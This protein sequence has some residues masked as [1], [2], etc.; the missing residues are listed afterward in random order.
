MLRIIGN[1]VSKIFAQ[2]KIIAFMFIVVAFSLLPAV[3]WA[4][5][6]ADVI[7]TGQNLPLYML[8]TVNSIIPI[9]LIVSLGDLI[10]DEYVN[11]T[12]KIPLL[13]PVSRAKLLTGKLL[14]Q[15]VP[16]A[17]LSFLGM[18]A[19][20][21]IGTLL[22]GWGEGFLYNE[23]A[24]SAGTGILLTLGSYLVSLL[25]LMVFAAVVMFFCLQLPSGG[26]AVAASIGVLL[27][28]SLLGQL[29]DSIRPYLIITY[30]HE[31]SN[32]LFFTGDAGK[33]LLSLAVMAVYGVMFYFGSI[34]FFRKKDLL[35]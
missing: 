15:I 13:H 1:E 31:F 11:G 19:A 33:I 34:L 35:Y 8:A 21:G 12:L 20:Y 10:S 22:F 18:A 17:L 4:L 32:Y 14:A 26:A 5:G 25:P 7:F 23:S 28:L 6:E 30:F 29:L 9:Y 27:F 16:A 2:K 24:A 3:E